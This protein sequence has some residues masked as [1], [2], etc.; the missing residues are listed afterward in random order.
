MDWLQPHRGR[1]PELRWQFRPDSPLAMAT[2]ARES[3]ETYLVDEVGHLYRLD[4]GGQLASINRV[5][6]PVMKLAWSDTGFLGA[7]V[8]GGVHLMVF[9]QTLKVLWETDAPEEIVGIAVDPYGNYVAVAMADRNTIVMSRHRRKV[10]AFESV[11]PLSHLAFLADE[12]IIV[13]AAEHGLLAGYSLGGERLWTE[14]VLCGIGSLTVAGNG[15]RIVLAG[16]THGVPIHDEVGDSL[17]SMMVEGTA[18]LAA[19]DITCDR[20]LISTLE[21]ALYW[22]DADGDILWA[23]QTPE[24]ADSLDVDPFGEFIQ[25]AF[26]EL[27]VLRLHWDQ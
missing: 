13:G 23:G 6:E 12:P 21:Q 27:G 20:M 15:N 14:K 1:C 24:V 16:F 18:F 2:L 17:G 19:A 25:P 10:A 7:G 4:R 11:R 22:V 3:G 5:R 8:A 26:A 9:D